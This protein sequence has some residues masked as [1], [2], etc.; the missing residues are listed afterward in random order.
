MEQFKAFH[1]WEQCRKNILSILDSGVD[2]YQIPNGYQNNLFWNA[3]HCVV[4]QQILCYH[5]SGLTMNYPQEIIDAYKKGTKAAEKDLWTLPQL[6]E[7]MHKS[8]ELSKLDYQNNLFQNFTPYP[9]SFGMTLHNVH[10]AFEYNLM[11]E[12]LH[13]GYMLGLKKLLR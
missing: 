7:E 4:T 8:I 5:L 11:H 2:I 12:S 1:L 9:T 6:K 3:A 10:E 13:V